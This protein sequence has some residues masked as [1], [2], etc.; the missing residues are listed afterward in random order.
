[1]IFSS[2][3]LLKLIFMHCLSLFV[4][5]YKI[6]ERIMVKKQNSLF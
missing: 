2:Y 4:S 1:M 3:T 6:I 5:F